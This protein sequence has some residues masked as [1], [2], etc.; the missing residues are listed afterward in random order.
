MGRVDPDAHPRHVEGLGHLAEKIEVAVKLGAVVAHGPVGLAVEFDLG[1][2]FETDSPVGS[3]ESDDA[4]VFEERFPTRIFGGDVAQE[5]L[6]PARALVGDGFAAAQAE[7]D[8]FVLDTHAPV[9][10]VFLSGAEIADEIVP[11]LDGPFE[12]RRSGAVD[13]HGE[14]A[15]S[16]TFPMNSSSAR[17]SSSRSCTPMLRHGP[18]FLPRRKGPTRVTSPLALTVT[19]PTMRPRLTSNSMARTCF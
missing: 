13:G 9:G 16:A 7:R 11:A 2:G 18:S 12:L 8:L 17:S 4:P 19:M 3:V 6:D 1:A 10:C 15:S 5:C 14:A